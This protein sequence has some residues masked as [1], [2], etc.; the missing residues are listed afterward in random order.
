LTGG[1]VAPDVAD[2]DT[3]SH[4]VTTGL[5]TPLAADPDAM[6][7]A[8]FDHGVLIGLAAARGGPVDI[9]VAD[10][11]GAA[12]PEGSV[13]VVLDSRGHEAPLAS[14]PC[15]AGCTR[16]DADVLTG[17]ATTLRVEVTLLGEPQAG[18]QFDLPESL[19]RDGAELFAKARDLMGSLGALRVDQTLASGSSSISIGFEYVAPDRVRYGTSAGTATVLIG[20]RRWDL[21]DGTWAHAEFPGVSIPS[22]AWEDAG[23]ARILG[24]RQIGGE[25]VEILSVFDPE[26]G[27]WWFELNVASDG[28]VLESRMIGP[29]HDMFERYHDLD[30]DISIDPPT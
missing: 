10:A 30:G 2:E 22:Y 24:S 19:P 27:P 14:R 7:T 3:L 29:A 25:P 11:G 26:Q 23:H 12:V 1:A 20:K 28:R 17:T 13:R 5:Q 6:T 18:A 21:L 16:V 8:A 9:L 15:G 4:T